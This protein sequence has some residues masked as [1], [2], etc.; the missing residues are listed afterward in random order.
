MHS[1]A[2][3]SYFTRDAKSSHNY[4][5]K[6]GTQSM[7]LCWV[8]IGDYTT[9]HPSYS[10]APVKHGQNGVLYDSCVDDVDNPSTFVV[11]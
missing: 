9:G 10:C 8:F 2:T 4:T 7:F 5:D 11:F 3:G 1:V 6:S